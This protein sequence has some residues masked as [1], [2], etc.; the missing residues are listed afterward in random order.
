MSG[1]IRRLLGPTNARL[2]GYVKKARTIFSAPI[3]EEDLDKEETMVEDVLQRITTNLIL[4]KRCNSDW[5]ALLKELKGD[6]KA[7]EEKEYVWATEGDDGLIE[8][9]LD[10]KETAS[11]LSA[12]LAK[13]TRLQEKV[14]RLQERAQERPLTSMREPSKREQ[15]NCS[16]QMK[17]PK[18]QLPIFEGDILQWQ[19]F[20]DIYNSAVHEQDI[21]NVTKFSYLKG[22]LRNSAAAAICGISVMNDNYPVAIHILEDKFG[23]KEAIIE[24]L[25]SQ[26]QHL[27]TVTNRFTEVKSTYETIERILRQLEAQGERVDQYTADFIKVSNKFPCQT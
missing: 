24:A 10:S 13:V 17:L 22:S 21:P 5:L 14:T 1:P 26:L 11:C 27:P 25:Y 2:L 15:T 6:E 20:W 23:K 3:D 18:L 7:V 8:L 19:E 4:L 9:L 16:V 12:R